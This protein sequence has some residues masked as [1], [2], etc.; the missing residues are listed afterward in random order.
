MK[1]V[2]MDEIH[3]ILEIEL[4]DFEYIVIAKEKEQQKGLPKEIHMFSNFKREDCIKIMGEIVTG[5][6][7]KTTIENTVSSKKTNNFLKDLLNR[8]LSSDD[9]KSTS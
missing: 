7:N 4:N 5:M 8:N 3:R 2:N 1:K 9:E 6:K